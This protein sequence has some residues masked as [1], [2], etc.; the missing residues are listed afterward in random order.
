MND[1]EIIRLT[2]GAPNRRRTNSKES[3]IKKANII[4]ETYQ[5]ALEI[6][7]DNYISTIINDSINFVR[8]IILDFLYFWN[9]PEY[10]NEQF[11][12]IICSVGFGF[13]ALIGSLDEDNYEKLNNYFMYINPDDKSK[14]C[15]YQ[16]IV[17]N[18]GHIL[19]NS[20]K[21]RDIE[22]SIP[23]DLLNIM[24]IHDLVVDFSIN[25]KMDNI[26]LDELKRVKMKDNNEETQ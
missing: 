8:N 14:Y 16:E 6:V 24:D 26:I 22:V 1:E 9:I 25:T 21:D 13:E 19:Y 23:N 20:F 15:P 17:F 10:K 4:I 7:S 5:K 3:I 18:A 11:V 2:V 12:Q